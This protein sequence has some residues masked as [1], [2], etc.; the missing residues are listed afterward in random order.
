MRP[1]NPKLGQREAATTLRNGDRSSGSFR[2]R[3][4]LPGPRDRTY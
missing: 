2:G 4:E 1:S 3:E